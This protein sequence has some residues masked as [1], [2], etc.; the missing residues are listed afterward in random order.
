MVP[1]VYGIRRPPSSR[2]GLRQ[3]IGREGGKGGEV[4]V[5]VRATTEAVGGVKEGDPALARRGLIAGGVADEDRMEQA[6]SVEQHAEVLRLGQ[7][8][9]APALE[10][11]EVAPE[12]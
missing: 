7:A 3:E 5:G 8:G 2:P 1:L 10:V 12:P 11:A 9:V 4:V 6:V